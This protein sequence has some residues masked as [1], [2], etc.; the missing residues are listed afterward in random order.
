MVQMKE[1]KDVLV[2]VVVL[3]GLLLFAPAGWAKPPAVAGVDVVHDRCLVNCFGLEDQS[4]MLGC[5]IGCDNAAAER[6]VDEE[7]TLSSE[8]YVARW[9]NGG[10][11]AASACHGTAPCPA[12]YGS[13][14]SWSSYTACGGPYCGTYIYCCEPLGPTGP[15]PSAPNCD[16]YYGDAL[17]QYKE[18]YRVCFNASGQSCTEYQRTSYI[19][20]CGCF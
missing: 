15:A 10:V 14:A 8:E 6:T 3:S 20:G 9:G 12:E 2:F 7:V 1:V 17:R 18:R 16:F 5:L 19:I 4:Q 11:T 13:C